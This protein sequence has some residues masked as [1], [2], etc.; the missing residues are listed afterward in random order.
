MHAISDARRHVTVP[1]HLIEGL[2][3]AAGVQREACPPVVPRSV[4]HDIASGRSLTFAAWAAAEYDYSEHS[5]TRT[6]TEQPAPLPAPERTL[7]QAPRQALASGEVSDTD[8]AEQSGGQVLLP[9]QAPSYEAEPALLQRSQHSLAFAIAPELA[10]APASEHTSLQPSGHLSCQA[11]GVDEDVLAW[12]P[13]EAADACLPSRQEASTCAAHNAGSG[14]SP[15]AAACA[16]NWAAQTPVHTASCTNGRTECADKA[17]CQVASSAGDS[18][19]QQGNSNSAGADGQSSEEEVI[20]AVQNHLSTGVSAASPSYPLQNSN[21]S[22]GMQTSCSS[23]P[24]AR[25]AFEDARHCCSPETPCAAW[26]GS[27]GAAFAAWQRV[28]VLL[29]QRRLQAAAP[30]LCRNKIR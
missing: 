12:S 30:L 20:S 10:P 4:A 5:S 27:A 17:S 18:Q 26:D 14:C 1:L 29:W 8:I 28:T 16:A 3:V 13:Q 2:S 6:Q 9:E 23:L 15:S 25:Q 7:M 22:D 21:M 11:A 19:S 24:A